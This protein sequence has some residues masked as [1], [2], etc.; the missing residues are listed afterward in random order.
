MNFV[1]N[2]NEFNLLASRRRKLEH[3]EVM[4]FHFY[5]EIFFLISLFHFHS[6]IQAVTFKFIF[7]HRQQHKITYTRRI[8]WVEY[9]FFLLWALGF[10]ASHSVLATYPLNSLLL[11]LSLFFHVWVAI[12]SMCFCVEQQRNDRRWRKR[13]KTR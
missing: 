2:S 10:L 11:I 4:N 13:K 3:V 5:N 7:A 9:F 6:G 12:L 1:L 8:S